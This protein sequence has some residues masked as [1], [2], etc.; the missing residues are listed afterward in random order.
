MNC[1]WI[2][3][4]V[5]LL[6][7]ASPAAQSPAT[8]HDPSPHSVQFVT[9]DQDVK[10]EV[11]DWGGSGRP[12]VLLPGGGDTAHVYDDFAPKLT[13]QYHVYGITRRGYGAST[14]PL[15]DKNN[16]S[17][18][19]L[20]DDVLAVLDALEIDHPVLVGHSAGGEELSSIGS[21]H[22]ERIAGLIYLDAAY[23]YAYYDG[24]QGFL[25]IDLQELRDELDQLNPTNLTDKKELVSKLRQEDLPRFEKDLK[26]MQNSSAI[27]VP[28]PPPMPGA[29]DLASF[30]VFRSWQLRTQ[31]IA[32]PESELRLTYETTPG[33]GVGKHREFPPAFQAMLEQMQKYTDLR[34]PI[35]AI[36]ADPQDW[37]TYKNIADRDA[38]VLSAQSPATWHDPSPHT[39]RF[40][41]VDQDVKLEVLDWGGSGRGLVLLA[42][43][44]STAHVYDDFAPK[45]TSEYHVYGITRR[46][47]GASSAPTPRDRNYSA[48]RLGDDVLA[49]LDVLKLERPVLVGHSIAGEEL[50]SIGSRHPKRV[51]GLNY[52]DA[53][54]PYAYYDGSR[55]DFIVDWDELKK[56]VDQI[57]S[58][59]DRT[60]QE[61]FLQQLLQAN[62]PTFGKDLQKM[63]EN[64]ALMPPLKSPMPT[65]A[66]RESF[67]AALAWQ[68]K[69]YGY[70]IPEAELR[71]EAEATPEGR[72]GGDRANPA[73]S[74][75]IMAGEQKYTNLRV[76]ILAI[77][78]LPQDRGPYVNANNS[79]AVVAAAEARNMAMT[80]AQVA[81]F[82]VGVPSARVVR[83]PH[84]SHSLF[85]SNEADVL[86]EIRS[87]LANLN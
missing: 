44:G 67:T 1:S 9:V 41:T 22:P 25:P 20:G 2:L 4:A 16:Y 57:L 36:Y 81:A 49:V 38:A 28:L 61:Q 21:R 18:D 34:V 33:G 52:L 50:S 35:L 37:G 62:L 27:P 85:I 53:A 82:E 6:L 51:A 31:G 78:A 32:F 54:F 45:L 3:T 75:A 59:V 84:A 86:R 87:F 58:G 74:E 68:K 12:L 7:P 40:V 76:P 15:P 11:L 69:V 30:E 60:T 71:E 14:A 13:S 19:R 63:R 10:L 46:G 65:P 48:D 77:F 26:E 39:V 70:A 72:V 64:L 42:G 24:S 29:A 66:D 79:P 83:L 55:G 80:G 17:S 43:L 5:L 8:W 23:Q 56:K 47:F 73:I